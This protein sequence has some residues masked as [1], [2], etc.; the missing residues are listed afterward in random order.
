MNQVFKKILKWIL[1]LATLCA[2]GY[3]G[4]MLYNYAVEN[5]TEK[6]KK[7]VAEGIG[8]GVGS[9]IN[10]LSWPAKLFGQ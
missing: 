1:I 4:Y 7:G 2:L 10:P 9:A 3:G 5:A 6:I 8:K